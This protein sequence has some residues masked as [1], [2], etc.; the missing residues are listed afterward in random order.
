MAIPQAAQGLRN[1]GLRSLSSSK[2]YLNL[3]TKSLFL[4]IGPIQSEKRIELLCLLFRFEWAETFS[5]PQCREGVKFRYPAWGTVEGLYQSNKH[6]IMVIAESALKINPEI[7]PKS[8]LNTTASHDFGLS[9]VRVN[10]R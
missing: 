1:D 10:K 4:G 2:F 6:S 3:D 8:R 5:A 7:T 9:F